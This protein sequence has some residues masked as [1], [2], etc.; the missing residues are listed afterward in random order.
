MDS[1]RFADRAPGGT[2][3]PVTIRVDG[4]RRAVIESVRPSISCRSVPVKRVAGDTLQVSADAFA[5]GHDQLGVVL[6]IRD[7]GERR[8][9]EVRMRP[10]GNDRWQGE[11]PLERLGRSTFTVRAWVDPFATWRGQLERRVA[12][13]QDVKVELLV[14]AD[15]VSQAADAAP[16]IR[17]RG[18]AGRALRRSGC[19][20]RRWWAHGLRAG[21]IRATPPE[22]TR[23]S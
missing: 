7:E 5:D 17:Q 3:Q 2:S 22:S 6:R 8:W 10:L 11:T 13:G 9:R 12:G 4:R 16:N 14:G 23:I 20:I 15:L 21:R 1:F 18:G 19:S